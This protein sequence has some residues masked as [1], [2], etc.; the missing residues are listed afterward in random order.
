MYDAVTARTM[1]R[2]RMQYSGE[3]ER[4]METLAWVMKRK[5]SHSSAA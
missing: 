2:M 3:A 5:V 1:V 4:A